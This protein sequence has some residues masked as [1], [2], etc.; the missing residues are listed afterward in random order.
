MNECGWRLGRDTSRETI[1]RHS[2]SVRASSWSNLVFS[3]WLAMQ[4]LHGATGRL[5][6]GDGACTVG[7]SRG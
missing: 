6:G 7:L 4:C 5:F 3:T 2:R 1:S